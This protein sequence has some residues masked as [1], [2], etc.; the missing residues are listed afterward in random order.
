MAGRGAA[1]TC[2]EAIAGAG[3]TISDSLKAALL[4]AFLNEFFGFGPI[5]PLLEDVTVTEVMVNGPQRV[6]VERAG[7]LTLSTVRFEDNDHVRRIIDRIILPLGRRIDRS[8]R[9]LNR[10]N[11]G[12]TPT[13]R[14]QNV[15]EIVLP[16]G[17][18]TGSRCFGAHRHR[19]LERSD[20]LV[21]HG[22]VGEA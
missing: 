1:A 3:L 21:G 16:H 5:Q 13:D 6:Y 11:V 17:P 12:I 22:H 10:Q 14:D 18:A 9:F 20:R 15:E 19:L 4:R 2:G 8:H 7:K